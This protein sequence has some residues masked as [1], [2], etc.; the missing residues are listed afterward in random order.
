MPAFKSI[1]QEFDEADDF[2][3]SKCLDFS[4]HPRVDHPGGP[5]KR[6]SLSFATTLCNVFSIFQ[7]AWM[8]QNI[9]EKVRL[10]FRS[11]RDVD[12]LWNSFKTVQVDHAFLSINPPDG[13]TFQVLVTKPKKRIKGCKVLLNNIPFGITAQSDTVLV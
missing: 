9:H 2:D 8:K 1:Q 7:R 3:N 5:P 11:A 6:F 12:E 10:H 4:S 13:P